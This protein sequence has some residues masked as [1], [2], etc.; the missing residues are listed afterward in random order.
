MDEK[1]FYFNIYLHCHHDYQKYLKIIKYIP[2]LILNFNS[3]LT[4]WII[5][6]ISFVV[7]LDQ[8]FFALA[9]YHILK[10]LTLPMF[11]QSP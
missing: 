9:I 10:I 1:E 7:L 11:L 2:K 4:F 3:V 8:Y 5:S 6:K